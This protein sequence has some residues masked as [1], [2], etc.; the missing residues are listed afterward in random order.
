M[1]EKA[2]FVTVPRILAAAARFGLRL[3]GLDDERGIELSAAQRDGRIPTGD[4]PGP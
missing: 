4:R 2:P 3:G 1:M